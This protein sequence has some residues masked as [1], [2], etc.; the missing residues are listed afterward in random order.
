MVFKNNILAEFW[1][2]NRVGSA[3]ILV[4]LI[5]NVGLFTFL[6]LYMLP[7]LQR[8]QATLVQRQGILRVNGSEVL[9]QSISQ[10]PDILGKFYAQV[11]A[12]KKFPEFLQQLYQY[13]A[14]AG[15]TIERIAYRPETTELSTVL[16]YEM[17]FS[18]TGQYGQIKEFLH[19]LETWPQ[20][21]VVEQVSLSAQ[22]PDRDE[23]V[24]SIRLAAYFN[25]VSS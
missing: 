9:G 12:Y 8:D 6:H 11:G 7:G 17:D 14:D 21:V 19:A 4:G 23:V 15:L 2:T 3:L 5:I 13:S 1:R 16:R 10:A 24:F 25:T 22:K 20:L 18:V